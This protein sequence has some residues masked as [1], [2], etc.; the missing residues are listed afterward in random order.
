MSI[1]MCQKEL[2]DK[3][4]QLDPSIIVDGV[5]DEAQ[6]IS[7]PYRIMY[8]LKEVNGGSGWSLCDHLQSGGRGR[9]HDPTWDNIARWTEGIFNLQKELPWSEAEKDCWTRREKMLPKICAINV[10]KTSGSYVSKNKEVYTAALNNANILRRQFELYAPDI[11]ICCGTEQ[12]FVNAC[13]REKQIDWKMTTRGVWHFKDGNKIVITVS[14][15]AA[16]VKDCYLYY[17][18]LDAV[19]EI[20]NVEVK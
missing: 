9:E 6:Y 18:L 20:L 5:P 8:V 4:R 2:F 19:R 15:P 16:R 14:H 3:L 17:A 11:V 7:A 12:A 1:A 13:F 10:K